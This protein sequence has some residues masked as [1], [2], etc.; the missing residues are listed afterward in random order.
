MVVSI[1][2]ER[3]I[4]MMI[5]DPIVEDDAV[6]Y[7]DLGDIQVYE[8]FAHN[9]AQKTDDILQEKSGDTLEQQGVGD[10]Q[11]DDRKIHHNTV[12][13]VDQDKQE[14]P[15]MRMSSHNVFDDEQ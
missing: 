11:K 4:Q 7:S 9:D 15:Q 2:G 6:D 14:D 13:E 1:F 3:D 12:E 8:M 5:D 10:E